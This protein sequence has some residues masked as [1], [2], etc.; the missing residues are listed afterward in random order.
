MK[1]PR[2][3]YTLMS[4][5]PRPRFPVFHQRGWSF[6][7][8]RVHQSILAPDFPLALYLT[9]F[10]SQASAWNDDPYTIAD[11]NFDE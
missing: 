7:T 8:I 1:I 3:S 4:F 10:Y 6:L 11:M 5:P 2:M 9:N